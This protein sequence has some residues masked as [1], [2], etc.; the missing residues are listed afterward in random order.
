MIKQPQLAGVRHRILCFA[1]ETNRKKSNISCS[2][3]ADSSSTYSDFP[4]N[5]LPT[6]PIFPE[7]KLQERQR[8]HVVSGMGIT[9]VACRGC[10]CATAPVLDRGEA[11]NADALVAKGI[12]LFG[13]GSH[14]AKPAADSSALA[15]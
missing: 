11:G 10:S 2:K 15:S 14:G 13:I 4:G 8:G 12:Q 3:S 9:L 6:P 7:Q 5:C 1:P